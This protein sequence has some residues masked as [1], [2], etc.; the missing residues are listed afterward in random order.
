VQQSFLDEVNFALDECCAWEA[1]MGA[2]AV[3]DWNITIQS[4][5]DYPKNQC[6]I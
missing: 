4:A 6:T 2:N 3:A 1:M 5:P